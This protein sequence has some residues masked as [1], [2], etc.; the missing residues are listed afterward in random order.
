ML[1]MFFHSGASV[2]DCY[3]SSS[4]YSSMSGMSY[5]KS[6]P[7]IKLLSKKKAGSFYLPKENTI[8]N[9]KTLN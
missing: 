9:T 1:L 5:F 2:K 6:N 7:I 8:M 4:S 3:S